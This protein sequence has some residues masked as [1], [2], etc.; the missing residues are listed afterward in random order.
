MTLGQLR[1]VFG[2]PANEHM[3][4]ECAVEAK[5]VTALGITAGRP[6]RLSECYYGVECYP[7][8]VH[9]GGDADP[10]E[11]ALSNRSVQSLVSSVSSS[12]PTATLGLVML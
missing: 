10:L 8:A 12:I 7:R 6:I 11:Q 4:G 2:I 5:H 3:L 9:K 1:A